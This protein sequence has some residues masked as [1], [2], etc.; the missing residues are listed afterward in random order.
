MPRPSPRA[1]L[2]V[3][4]LALVVRLGVAASEG[5]FL[6]EI[7]AWQL[8]ASPVDQVLAHG[9]VEPIPPGF[10]LLLGPW[11]RWTS[12]P[13]LLRLPS[14]LAAVLAAGLLFRAGWRLGGPAVAL[15][16]SL[17]LAVTWTGWIAD[18][19]VRM[20]GLLV[21]LN[22]AVLAGWLALREEAPAWKR[23]AWWGACLALPLVHYLGLPTL[24][25]LALAR[26]R[27]RLVA[28]LLA[29]L[30]VGAGWLA[31]AAAGTR[32]APAAAGLEPWA[33]WAV[34]T[35]PAWLTGLT[36]VPSWAFFRGADPMPG[37]ATEW[38]AGLGGLGLWVLAAR[39]VLVLAR[40]D[41]EAAR[42]LAALVL[43]PLGTVL[44][45]AALG[46]QLFQQRYLVPSAFAFFLALVLGIPE[47][48]RPALLGA[49]V[50]VNL[51]T[52]ALFPGD[53]YLWNQDWRPVADF[54]RRHET[55][56]DVLVAHIPY[57]LA[58]FNQYY[59]TR[60]YRLDF[61]RK[62]EIPRFQFDPAYEGV[63]QVG[64]WKAT[65]LAGGLE[66]YLRGRRVFLLFNQEDP[67]EARV[68][69]EWFEARYEVEAALAVP[70]LH[71]WGRIHAWRLRPRPVPAPAQ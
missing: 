36:V 37:A 23:V 2:G 29:G 38:V 32:N 53:P 50:A 8:A 54:V 48:A 28:P 13:F 71:D 21:L 20:Y 52:A 66:D 67:D 43:V 10:Y 40:R 9:R 42:A 12:D 51:A 3:M 27:R 58:G 11:A 62:G 69:L 34:W 4:L 55:G 5:L 1:L 57:S 31:F 22:V 70:S 41:R 7:Y 18:T 24:A 14:L 19:Q 25:A 64:V 68:L 6:D 49:L 35:L 15:G 26:P 47:R 33:P 17:L 59:A 46:F 61:S 44:A 60:L 30:A 39:G 65:A 45:G 63:A 56:G 16:A